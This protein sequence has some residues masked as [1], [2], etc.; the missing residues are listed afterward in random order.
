MAIWGRR[1][2]EVEIP[3]AFALPSHLRSVLPMQMQMD[4]MII[5]QNA[6][7]VYCDIKTLRFKWR[8][9]FRYMCSKKDMDKWD[10]HLCTVDRLVL[11]AKTHNIHDPTMTPVPKIPAETVK[12]YPDWATYDQFAADYVEFLEKFIKG[13]YK[14]WRDSKEY[15]EMVVATCG[16]NRMD[17]AEWE[18]WWTNTFLHEMSK[19]EDSLKG[20]VLP[21][22]EDLIKELIEV[23]SATV[24]QPKLVLDQIIKD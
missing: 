11:W 19:F 13:S 22:W 23:V 5:Q 9:R 15:V 6:G 24:D 14:I 2:G 10:E 16:M 3:R 21:C 7:V 1:P 12:L 8:N 20:L 18:D 4:F 17:H